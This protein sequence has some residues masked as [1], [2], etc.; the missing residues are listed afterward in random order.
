LLSPYLY[1]MMDNWQ[2]Q[3]GSQFIYPYL[4]PCV[5]L[6]KEVK[7]FQQKYQRIF[8]YTLE[9]KQVPYRKFELAI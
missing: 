5:I 7:V 8:Q 1:M 6:N 9:V 3:D 4:I 2:P